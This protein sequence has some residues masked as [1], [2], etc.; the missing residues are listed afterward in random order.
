VLELVSRY[1]AARRE[2]ARLAAALGA[3]ERRVAELEG[4]LRE[5]NQLR[6]DVAKRIDDLVGQIDQIE[7]RFA[8]RGA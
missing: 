4:A 8:A 7:G 5:A 2:N 3:S 6:S 1:G